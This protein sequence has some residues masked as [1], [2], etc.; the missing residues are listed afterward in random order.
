MFLDSPW[1]F[2]PLLGLAKSWWLMSEVGGQPTNADGSIE[3]GGNVQDSSFVIGQDN[4][5][6][7]TGGGQ[8][9]GRDQ[10]LV[11]VNVYEKPGRERTPRRR[12][13]TDSMATIEEKLRDK[14]NQHDVKLERLDISVATD[15]KTFTD[16]I[17]DLRSDV[18]ELKS[19]LKPLI[20]MNILATS[21]HRTSEEERAHAA[22]FRQLLTVIAIA[23]VIIAVG[24][25][26]LVTFLS[27]GGRGAFI[28]VFEETAS[29]GTVLAFA[30]SYPCRV[31]LCGSA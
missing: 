25:V 30:G 28:P 22:G 2:I 14:L 15:R 21:S 6:T 31:L 23:L 7:Q 11:H 29:Q 4:T 1:S 9:G 8:S 20:G 3:V 26:I 18:R 13:Q 24:L 16:Y 10:A 12:R 27:L 5:L 19:D 17:E